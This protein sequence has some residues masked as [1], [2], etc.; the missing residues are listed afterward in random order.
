M[1]GRGGGGSKD[2]D[3]DDDDDD[4]GT[5]V[6]F[7]IDA[8]EVWCLDEI[9]AR[10]MPACKAHQKLDMLASNVHP[11]ACSSSGGSGGSGSAGGDPHCHIAQELF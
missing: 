4:V 7:H 10:G 8:L 11:P 2:D 3:N 9:A 6:R 5:T 1:G